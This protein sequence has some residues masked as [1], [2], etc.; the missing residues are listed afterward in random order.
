M[1]NTSLFNHPGVFPLEAKGW[2]SYLG[3]LVND[4][5]IHC[6]L[7]VPDFADTSAKSVTRVALIVDGRRHFYIKLVGETGAKQSNDW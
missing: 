6:F 7:T 2:F 5:G 1:L 4:R 3:K